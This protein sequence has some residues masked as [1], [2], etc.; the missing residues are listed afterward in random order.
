MT[1]GTARPRAG[2]RGIALYLLVLLAVVGLGAALGTTGHLL[3]LR[4][5]RPMERALFEARWAA[6][7]GVALARASLARDPAWSGGTMPVGPG[8]V[9]V[10][11]T[12]PAAPEDLQ[13]RIVRSTGSRG[14]GGPGGAD[15]RV[16]IT[17]RLRLEV[18]GTTL[19][20]WHEGP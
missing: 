13:V 19:L 3:A 4:R 14:F 1:A 9:A 15:A 18:G 7:G 6:E 5:A 2:E 11:V 10:S 16:R 17:A 8:E 12:V 20:G